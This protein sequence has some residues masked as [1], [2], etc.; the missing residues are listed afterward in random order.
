MEIKKKLIIAPVILEE[1]QWRAKYTAFFNGVE[2]PFIDKVT[3]NTACGYPTKVTLTFTVH[4]DG[5]SEVLLKSLIKS[6]K[7]LEKW[8]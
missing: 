6:S 8:K 4:K 7:D 2:L 5:E 1:D 3:I